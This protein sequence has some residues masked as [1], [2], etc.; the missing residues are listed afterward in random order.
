M[1]PESG[2]MS[3][4]LSGKYYRGT[5]QEK[6]RLEGKPQGPQDQ[7]PDTCKSITDHFFQASGLDLG[8]QWPWFHAR[9]LTSP[10]G[11][12]FLLRYL[13]SA[14]PYGFLPLPYPGLFSLYLGSHCITWQVSR[15]PSM[16]PA[17]YS[18]FQ[19]HWGC[20]VEAFTILMPRLYPRP[21][22]SGCLGVGPA[23]ST[24]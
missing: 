15:L 12:A 14:P 3:K 20:G 17:S 5:G 19:N 4:V 16:P 10:S 22:K 13:A 9:I 2:R 21:I 6:S 18:A 8:I 1:R 7:P 24:F 11:L 23:I